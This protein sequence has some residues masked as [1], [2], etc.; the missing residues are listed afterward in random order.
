[1][2]AAPIS[3]GFKAL[4]IGIK[5]GVS[6]ILSFAGSV[7]GDLIASKG[8][9]VNWAKAGIMAAL[10]IAT[11]IIGDKLLNP[12]KHLDV[13]GIISSVARNGEV[14]IGNGFL[15]YSQATGRAILQSALKWNALYWAGASGASA[16]I[17]LPF[18][19]WK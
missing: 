14:I 10:G 11:S 16:L 3:T 9:N 13:D 5:A 8:K 18:G 19:F 15:A 2:G 17:S 12:L 4:N 7:G 6:G 1:M